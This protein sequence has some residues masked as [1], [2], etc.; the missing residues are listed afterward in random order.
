MLTETELKEIRSSIK[1]AKNIVVIFDGDADGLCSYLTLKKVMKCSY[2]IA[3]KSS[4]ILKEEIYINKIKEINP[5]LVVILDKP[6]VA[7]EFIDKINARVIWIDH[8]LPLK[9]KNVQY[10]NPR[11]RDISD[12]TSVSYLCYKTAKKGL[13]VAAIG[14]IGDFQ[15][16]NIFKSVEKKY[17]LVGNT[18]DPGKI[19]F[20][21]K[22]GMLARIYSFM[23]KG[24]NKDVRK[25]ISLLEKIEDPREILEQSTENG[26]LIFERFKEIYKE[27]KL[28][29]D[30]ALKHKTKEEVLSYVYLDKKMS[31]TGEL[32]NELIYRFPSKMIIAGRIKN[33][34]VRLSIRSNKHNLLGIVEE[35]VSGL[36]GYGGGHEHACGAYIA[37]SDLELFIN[38]IK[39]LIKNGDKIV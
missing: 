21:T 4:P 13:W 11:I 30:D 32:S 23:L 31:F 37:E 27:Y 20:K 2:G 3:A 19:L 29:L 10:Y 8:H 12:N 25:Y 26:K 15:Y 22:L 17:G 34:R 35:A 33:N 24:R 5:D 1:K 18:K 14:V 36:D 6:I 38:R 7:Q 39:M 9:R 28:L 16:S